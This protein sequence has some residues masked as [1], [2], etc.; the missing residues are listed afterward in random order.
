M[1]EK[2]IYITANSLI[3][4]KRDISWSSIVGIRTQKGKALES[5]TPNFPRAE[6]FLKDGKV[7]V[8]SNRNVFFEGSKERD[9]LTKLPC[10]DA[11]RIIEKNS[12]NAKPVLNKWIEWRLFVPVILA[13]I[14][15]LCFALSQKM[16]IENIVLMV[17][18]AG[19]I[20]TPLGA[21]WERSERKKICQN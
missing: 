14:I 16:S 9:D 18:A 5:L 11:I 6:I 13:E 21:Y 12:V 2:K 1:F 19:I 3:V 15:A 7:V 8:V 4:G 20:G 17:I 10:K